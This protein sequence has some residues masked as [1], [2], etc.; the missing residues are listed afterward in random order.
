VEKEGFTDRGLINFDELT[1]GTIDIRINMG[2]GQ[3]RKEKWGLERWQ[4]TGK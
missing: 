2:G 1:A 3:G 4:K